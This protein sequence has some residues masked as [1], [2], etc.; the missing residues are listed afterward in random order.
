LPWRSISGSTVVRRDQ[1][2][3]G[4]ETV[5]CRTTQCTGPG[6]L[7]SLNKLCMSE[8]KQFAPG[9]IDYD[10]RMAA[11]YQSGRALSQEAASVWATIVATFV[12]RTARVR[13]LDLGAGTGRF[14]ALFARTL[15]VQ[16]I[17]VEPSKG[18]LAVATRADRLRN[19]SYVAGAAEGIPLRRHSCD[20]AW[21]SQVWHHIR[22][23][24]ACAS[25]LR[26]IVSRGGNVL[27]RGAFGDQL[28]GFPTLFRFWPA[29]R[30]IC[31]QLPTIQQTARVFET[32]GFALTE[33]RRVQQMTCGSLG[34][35]A[36]RTQL[37]ADTAL[38]LI[39]DAEYHEGQAAIER[40]AVNERL[41]TPV[42]EVIELLVF[43]HD[44]DS[45]SAV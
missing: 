18:L 6:A 19:L 25:E 45:M 34:E 28:D 11:S 33:H 14:S 24:Q 26:R 35:F 40:A 22:D 42:I 44:T 15:E 27:V 3:E 23:H 1:A 5:R 29:T 16:V 21:L 4:V 13:I 10:S 7:G 8:K 41:T 2:D 30:Q 20:L 39:S 43:H 36:K 37:R 9:V 31:Q 17:G 32:N 12:R 38:A